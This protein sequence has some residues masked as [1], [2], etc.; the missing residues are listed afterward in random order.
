MPILRSPP[1]DSEWIDP[2]EVRSPVVTFGA[3]I[4]SDALFEPIFPVA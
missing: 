1:F 4:F 3:S 2:D